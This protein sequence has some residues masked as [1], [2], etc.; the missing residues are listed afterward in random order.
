MSLTDLM[1]P[2]SYPKSI[3]PMAAVMETSHANVPV[4][5]RIPL[6]AD[7]FNMVSASLVVNFA[8]DAHV[9]RQDR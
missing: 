3:P 8:D 1:I 4:V 7:M 5:Q 6:R 2:V 9:N